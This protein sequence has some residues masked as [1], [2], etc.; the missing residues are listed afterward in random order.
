MATISGG[1]KVNA[2][3]AVNTSVSRT[4]SAGTTSSAVYTAPSNGFAII[5]PLIMF[6][7]CTANNIGD[8]G[9]ATLQVAGI[10]VATKTVTG[11][12]FAYWV[13]TDVNLAANSN[14]APVIY[15]GPGQSISATVTLSTSATSANCTVR[16]FGVEYINA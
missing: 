12:G 11:T 3:I 13:G 4:S 5:N 7:Q 8:T 15:L 6:S 16:F 9:A 14:Q 10:T 1:Y 2:A